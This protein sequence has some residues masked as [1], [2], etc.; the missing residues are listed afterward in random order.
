MGE[1]AE[2]KAQQTEQES[3]FEVKIQ[4]TQT[5]LDTVRQAE[6]KRLTESLERKYELQLKSLQA[7]LQ[8]V[9]AAAPVHQ[10]AAPLATAQTSSTSSATLPI[11]QT[12]TPKRTREPD[13][14]ANNSIG[15]GGDSQ[16]PHAK[17]IRV[18]EAEEQHPVN[19]VE[20][21]AVVAEEDNRIPAESSADDH[22][23]LVIEEDEQEEAHE[24]F[25][26]AGNEDFELEEGD[27]AE[28]NEFEGE[29]GEEYEDLPE[30]AEAE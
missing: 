22:P 4:E 17:R 30:P 28:E 7:T 12:P 20:N 24:D 23:D 15:A 26:E 10:V 11:H 1:I 5:R 27:D 21:D 29:E 18:V 6:I 3:M 9:Q 13:T 25:D 14:E 2:L 8:S 16:S 19:E